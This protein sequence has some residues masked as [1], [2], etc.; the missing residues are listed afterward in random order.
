M[1]QRR[2]LDKRAR[3]RGRKCHAKA[4]A[5]RKIRD[6]S[7]KYLLRNRIKGSV[8]DYTGLRTGETE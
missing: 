1:L 7:V 8:K 5:L 3:M 2:F 4:F 6:P